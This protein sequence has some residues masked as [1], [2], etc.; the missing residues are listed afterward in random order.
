DLEAGKPRAFY[1]DVP[2]VLAEDAL[3][4]RLRSD[5]NLKI[6]EGDTIR[7]GEPGREPGGHGQPPVLH[8]VL[9]L[10][11]QRVGVGDDVVEIAAVG[12]DLLVDRQRVHH[13]RELPLG[14][15]DHGP[16][17]VAG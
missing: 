8:W 5:L 3:H 4:K 15:G 9:S 12:G 16:H 14:S 17:L 1:Y 2:A 7:R 6:S 10:V 11:Q 13:A